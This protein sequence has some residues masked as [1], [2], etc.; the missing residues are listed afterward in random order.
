[1]QNYSGV[2]RLDCEFDIKR[3]R[4][5]TRIVRIEWING[6]PDVLPM[7]DPDGSDERE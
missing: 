6:R 5:R 2:D 1:M 7:S 3:G 4:N